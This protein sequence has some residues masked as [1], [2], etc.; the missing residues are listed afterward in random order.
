[1]HGSEIGDTGLFNCN[2]YISHPNASPIPFSSE[3]YLECKFLFVCFFPVF[4]TNT[5]A[6]DFLCCWSLSTYGRHYLRRHFSFVLRNEECF[7]GSLTRKAID[8][9]AIDGL[10]ICKNHRSTNCNSIFLN[11]SYIWVANDNLQAGWDGA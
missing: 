2:F 11:V 7:T 9:N 10:C 4:M 5:K 3:S 6:I 1:M 8:M